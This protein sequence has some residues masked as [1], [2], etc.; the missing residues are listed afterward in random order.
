MVLNVI[1]LVLVLGITFMHS[2]FGLYSGLLNLFCTVTALCVAFGFFEPLNN[3]LTGQAG[4]HPSFTEPASLVLLFVVT[5]VTLRVLSDTFL[6]GNVRVPMYLDWGGGALCG[7]LNAQIC[8]GVLVI[9]FLMLPWGGRVMLFS[10]FER[11]PEN[12]TYRDADD[13][14]PEL[15]KQDERVA[16]HRNAL[17]LRSD[18]FTVGL[19]NLLSRGSLR[20]DTT[21]ASVYPDFTEW[22]GWTGNTVQAESVTA[23]I[24]DDKGD[25]VKDGL[26]VETWW[27]QT[28]RLTQDDLRYRKGIPVKTTP[29]PPNEPLDYKIQPGHKLIGMRIDLLRAAADRDKQSAYHRFRPSMIRVVGDI[30][31]PDGTAE[32]QEYVPQLIGGADPNLGSYLRVVD[33]DNNFGLT[34]EAKT[35]VDVYFEVDDRFQPRFVEYRRHARAPVTKAQL[36]KA[37]PAERLALAAP[38][39]TGPGKQKGASGAGAARFIDT[40]NRQFT[41]DQDKLPFAMRLDKLRP[42]LDVQLDGKLL[43]SGRLASDRSALEVPER[44]ADQNVAKFKV[45]EGK[46]LFQLQTRPRR[47][48]SLPGQVMDFA[49]SVVNQYKAY[50]DTG[51]DYDLVGYYAI[52]KKGD[53][54][55]VELVYLPDDLS[56]RGMLDFKD[57]SV[58]KALQDQDSAV[59]GLL[60]LVPPGKGI[61]AVGSQGGR[62]DFGETIKVGQ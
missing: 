61:A 17:W 41:G 36:A 57:T 49:G 20:S 54:D 22:V 51:K 47:A 32:P 12:R 4:L 23:P 5:L 8:V 28:Q 2:M 14:P 50:D 33:L 56:F 29:K 44:E 52:V 40:V 7:L 27:E 21:F 13:V 43:A 15:R 59:L 48:R 19:F 35:P 26:K 30:E 11:D 3:L 46:R 55:Y 53:Q 25:G 16:F 24:R 38:E 18:Q 42:M 60:F 10:R 9:G 45:P 37:P 58:R 1:A 6:R 39:A 34:A 62:I 31:L